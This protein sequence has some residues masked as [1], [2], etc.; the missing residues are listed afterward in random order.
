MPLIL[1]TWR[2][3]HLVLWPPPSAQP[4]LRS[5]VTFSLLLLSALWWLKPG[6]LLVSASRMTA[7]AAFLPELARGDFS[8]KVLS[9]WGSGPLVSCHHLLGKQSG[10]ALMLLLEFNWCPSLSFDS[11]LAFP[12]H[13]GHL[14]SLLTLGSM[15]SFVRRSWKGPD[16]V[17]PL[18]LSIYLVS[19]FLS[20]LS[21]RVQPLPHQQQKRFAPG[22][23][24]TFVLF[25]RKY[26]KKQ[27][28]QYKAPGDRGAPEQHVFLPQGQLFGVLGGVTLEEYLDIA[29]HVVFG[30]NFS[31]DTFYHKC[32]PIIEKEPLFP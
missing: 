10:H 18:F 29:I 22:K 23:H 26:L 7:A 8:L 15:A 25:G 24:S 2:S 12:A 6:H 32:G 31:F 9:F 30:N 17:S 11:H 28:Y 1:W 5:W 14:F 27:G 3:W 21:W 20:C 13:Q 16:R 4:C 19:N